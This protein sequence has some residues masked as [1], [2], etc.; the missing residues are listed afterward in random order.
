MIEKVWLDRFSN[1]AKTAGII[2]ILLGIAGVLLPQFFSLALSYLIGWLLLF[3]ALTRA[4]S[5]YHYKERHAIAWL[6]PF[7]NLLVSLVF[8]LNAGIAIASLGLLLAFYFFMDAYA[9]FFV[10]RLFSAYGA[11]VWGIVNALIS[12]VLGI[13]ILLNWPMNSAWLVGVFVGITLFFDGVMLLFI[14]QKI[15]KR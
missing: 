12:F 4:Y 2:M 14:S 3:A 9:S 6:H 15:K 8:L 5:L 13:V 10:S 1:N 7:L 11:R